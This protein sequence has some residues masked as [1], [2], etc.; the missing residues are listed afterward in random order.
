MGSWV[1]AWGW[2]WDSSSFVKFRMAS[3]IA[4]LVMCAQVSE[5]FPCN[6]RVNDKWEWTSINLW[7]PPWAKQT[8]PALPFISTS[9]LPLSSTCT[10]IHPRTHTTHGSHILNQRNDAVGQR[11]RKSAPQPPS[12]SICSV[13][14]RA[15]ICYSN[16]MKAVDSQRHYNMKNV[17]YLLKYKV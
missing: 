5:S 17:K 16:I 7:G 15:E 13:K 3:A 6:H 2:R 12:S 11:W 14:V 4:A 8:E 9:P 1:Q 10:H